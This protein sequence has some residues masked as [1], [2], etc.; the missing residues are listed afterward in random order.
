MKKMLL[1]S[2]HLVILLIVI[3]C[4]STKV[5]TVP[6]SNVSDECVKLH[7]SVN[8]EGVAID[9]GYNHPHD[10][11]RETLR[12]ETDLLVVRKFEW[13]KYGMDNRWVAGSVFPMVAA[14]KLI[15]VLVIAFKEASISDKILFNI[16]GRKGLPTQGEVYLKDNKLFW[17]FKEIDGVTFL[18]KDPFMLDGKDWTIEEKPG[19]T[20]KKKK[21]AGAV[22]VIRD[23]SIKPEITTEITEDRLS[24]PPRKEALSPDLEGL[25]KKLNT[26]K[27]W[28]DSGLISN[29]DYEKEKDLIL[30][31]LQEL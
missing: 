24:Q 16:Q 27:K 13:G 8:A 31:Q 17:I 20:V 3:G 12:N 29:D 23:L 25:E 22:K 10:F 15:P 21:D 18:G 19:L 11:S 4:G 1:I 26:L 7:R 2:V 6:L 14:E 30:Q 5:L 28:K 9:M